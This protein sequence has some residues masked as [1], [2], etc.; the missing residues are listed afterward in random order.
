MSTNRKRL[1]NFTTC[2]TSNI[3]SSR[4]TNELNPSIYQLAIVT[5]NILMA[6][7]RKWLDFRRYSKS[8]LKLKWREDE[9][10][11]RQQSLLNKPSNLK[12]CSWIIFYECNSSIE[13]CNSFS[14]HKKHRKRKY[15][16]TWKW[17]SKKQE[18]RKI[19]MILYMRT[20]KPIG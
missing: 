19:K 1:W 7:K 16:S 20:A 15:A 9:E 4:Q 18:K 10:K 5:L 11:R 14:L 17:M 2:I 13:K 3:W 8:M 6:K 12:M